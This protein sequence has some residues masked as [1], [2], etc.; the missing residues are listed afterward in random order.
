MKYINATKFDRKSGGAQWRDLQFNGPSVEVF[1]DRS[2]AE[3]RDLRFLSQVFHG[4]CFRGI[5]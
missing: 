1:F 2:L 5:V 3:W 4:G